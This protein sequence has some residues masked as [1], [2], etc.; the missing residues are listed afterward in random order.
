MRWSYSAS[1][2]FRQCQRQWF[3]K[4]I[5]SNAKAKDPFRRQAYLLSKL[6]SI[7]AWRGKIVDDVL[8]QT[9][10]PNLNRGIR[11]NLRDIKRHARDRFDRQLAYARRHPINDPNLQ[12]SSEGEDF[13]VFHVMEYDGEIPKDEIEN[14]WGEIES[15][16]VNLYSMDS[17]KCL[18]RSSDYIISQRPLQFTLM[19]GITVIAYPDVIVFQNG[20]LPT[21]IDWK[22]H[23][24]GTNDAWLQLA[25]YA[26]ALCRCT[27]GVVRIVIF[28]V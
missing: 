3:F 17:I 22:V 20:S 19:D 26:I 5:A 8:S 25:I 12:V 7:S 16:L 18:M 24:F 11:M 14:A 21:I 1:R 2:S 6:Q 4:N 15:A 10:I 27:V 9:L 23:T 28:Q 13:S